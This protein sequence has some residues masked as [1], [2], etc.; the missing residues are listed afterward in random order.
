MKSH[1][2]LEAT[3]LS[4]IAAACYAFAITLSGVVFYALIS[5]THLASGGVGETFIGK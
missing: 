2:N 4:I 5:L 1:A 3:M